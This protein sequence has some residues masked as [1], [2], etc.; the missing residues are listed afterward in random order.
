MGRKKRHRGARAAMDMAVKPLLQIEFH[1]PM[2]S[3]RDEVGFEAN[4]LETEHIALLC[5]SWVS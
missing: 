1:W 4:F 2:A 3:P 5:V